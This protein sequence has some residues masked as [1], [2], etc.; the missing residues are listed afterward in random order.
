VS[1]L[2]SDQVGRIAKLL[3]SGLADRLRL[4]QDQ[5]ERLR[6]GLTEYRKQ[7]A[8]MSQRVTS[9]I[10]DISVNERGRKVPELAGNARK[11]AYALAKEL[12]AD[13]LE[14]LTPRQR[15]AVKKLLA[16]KAR[17]DNKQK[18]HDRNDDDDDD[19]D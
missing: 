10:G 2:Y 17:T 1:S 15:E 16:D 6:R 14:I 12:T 8:H 11:R 9:A 5:R 4:T 13:S 18:G 19:D 3:D 7:M